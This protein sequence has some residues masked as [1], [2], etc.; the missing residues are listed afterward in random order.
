VPA[1]SNDRLCDVGVKEV[2]LT[3]HY[4]SDARKQPYPCVRANPASSP[5]RREKCAAK[6]KSTAMMVRPDSGERG[7]YGNADATHTE[8]PNFAEGARCQLRLDELLRS[9]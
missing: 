1:S 3:E 9:P 4:I 8:K 5:K 7:S 6:G 2:T